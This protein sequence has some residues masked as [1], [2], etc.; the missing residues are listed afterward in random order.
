MV[1]YLRKETGVASVREWSGREARALRLALRLS[2]RLF[3]DHLGLAARTVSKWE[4]LGEAT[5]PRPDTQAVLD[6]ALAQ[7][8]ADVHARFEQLLAE[9]AAGSLV[10]PSTLGAGAVDYESWADDLDRALMCLSRQEFGGAAALINRWL[11]R[12]EPNSSDTQGMYLY[13][14]SL[15]LLGDVQQ[16]Q[17]IVAGPASAQR[18]YQKALSVFTELRL[19]RRVAQIELQLTVVD[20]MSGRLGQAADRYRVLAADER[21]DQRDRTRAQLWVGTA[22]SKRGFNESATQYIVPAIQTFEALDEA[23][24]WSIAHQKLALAHR[25]AGD[26][27]GAL[28]HIEVALANRRDAPMQQIRLDT[29]HAHILLSDRAT[30]DNGLAILRETARLSSHYGLKHQLQSIEGIRRTFERG[31]GRP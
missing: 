29:A 3:A 15:R 12:F 21:L 13:G 20:E 27:K 28:H 10:R 16:D 30:C 2:V 7:A 19:P 22:L 11:H 14:R 6:T 1:R 25:G 4:K 26:L 18:N 24:D 17:G 23:V 9:P 31:P 5:I 8:N